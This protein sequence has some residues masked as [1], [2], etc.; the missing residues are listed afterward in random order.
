MAAFTMCEDCAR[1]YRDPTDRRFHAEP[2][3]CP[4]CG[5]SLTL[6]ASGPSASPATVVSTA[7]GALLGAA[8]ALADGKIV[9]VKGIG[10]F[11]LACDATSSAAVRRLR[12]RK[13]REAKPLAVMIP[14]L[15][16]AERLAELSPEEADLLAAPERPIVLSR[17]RAAAPIAP[18]VAPDTDL[19]G[20]L[21]PYSPLH[22]LLLE[23]AGCPL[24]MTSGNLSEEPIAFRNSEAL[25]RLGGI[26]DLFL[27][28]D[29]EIEA[30]ADDSV[31]KVIR[32]KPLVM[33]RSRGWV[34]RGTRVRQ[35]FARPVL[36]CGAHLKNTF[37]IG[38]GDTAYLG[39][40]IGD[41]DNLETLESLEWNVARME[42]FLGVRPEM[43]AHDLH[44]AYM[45]T[46]YALERAARE[47][48]PAVA[49]QH[50]HAHAAAAMAEHGLDGSVLA[51]A[52]DGT[53]AGDDGTSW[54]S[55]LL[56]ASYDRY[57]RLA[58]FRPIALAGSD[59]AIR[60]PWRIALAVLDDAFDGAPPLEALP[61]FARVDAASV[62]VVR[63]MIA[64]RFNAPLAHGAGRW[65]DA[66]AALALGRTHALYEGQLA[67][68]LEGA[69]DAGER[70]PYPFELTPPQQRPVR[71]EVDLRPA[72]RAAVADLLGGVAAGIVSARFHLA[73]TDVAAS[74]V[75]LAS[76][77]HGRLPVVLTGG[78]FQNALLA[79][80][81]AR[82]IE[83][84]N[85]V[86]LHG[87]VPPGDGGI[88][89][90]QGVVA[91]RRA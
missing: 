87:S 79:A 23:G 47:A 11:H 32:G 28:H 9:A 29:R 37:C 69:A 39:P 45:S 49:V 82:K 46:R 51:L 60:E 72:V 58:T 89:L 7:D 53:G 74:L 2:N 59:R 6:I 81:A 31:A 3:A 4:R 30:R 91:A 8:R 16:S 63:Q 22:H 66:F 73:L 70:R 56:L 14:D 71:W 75:A 64:G 17:R 78:C 61:L 38:L 10:G 43:L 50:H 34:P 68:A 65:F 90:G 85:E 18:E 25:E 84:S 36:A 62:R 44:P 35:P 54:G 26:A 1:E 27:V 40:H 13:H 20:L 42:R 57:E 67:M 55:E 21:L 48:I 19:L 77:E 52:W 12:D 15:A 88:A 80:G 41:L 76:R 24:V 83:G 86:Y 5:P 33:R